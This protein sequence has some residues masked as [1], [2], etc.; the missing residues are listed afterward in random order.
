MI[1]A[2][3]IDV[4]LGLDLIVHTEAPQVRVDE[5]ASEPFIQDVFGGALCG[6]EDSRDLG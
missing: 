4:V 3:E 5:Q 1:G 6:G 2:D